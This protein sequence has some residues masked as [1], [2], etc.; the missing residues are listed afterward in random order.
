MKT[1]KERYLESN[2]SDYI[3]FWKRK[4]VSLKFKILN[5]LSGDTLRSGIAFPAM[6]ARQLKSSYEDIFDPKYEINWD[7]PT[8]EDIELIIFHYKNLHWEIDHIHDDLLDL[9]LI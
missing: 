1:I 7:N 8:K 6:S 4:D 3:D 5:M 9:F 2:L